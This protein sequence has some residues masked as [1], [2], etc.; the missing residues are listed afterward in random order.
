MLPPPGSFLRQLQKFA[1]AR[2]AAQN[3]TRASP[4]PPYSRSNV[5]DLALAENELI[6]KD[7]PE[8][9]DDGDDGD[10]C[11][12]WEFIP[13]NDNRHHHTTVN[14]HI[15]ASIN[16]R[17]NGN[18]LIIPPV[19]GP[20]QANNPTT[21]SSLPSSTM[22]QQQQSAQRHRQ[23][24]LT[25]M[26][27]SIITALGRASL[28]HLTKDGS[29]PVKININS[30]IKIEGSRNV[31]CPGNSLSPGSSLANRHYVQIS[32]VGS[33]REMDRKRRANSVRPSSP[34]ENLDY[35]VFIHLETHSVTDA[36]HAGATGDAP[37]K[38]SV[39][40]EA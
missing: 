21:S 15:D 6:D 31:I 9:A 30:G 14:I 39:M 5:P 2:A 33:L 11:M 17:G 35:E 24:K 37:R 7:E 36:L 18:T 28:L 22:Q 12:S 8:G 26:A 32:R 3:Q 4:P 27:T 25:G 19:A 20:Q 13:S 1:E 10:E 23:T 16:V 29:S 38:K 34:V 40:S